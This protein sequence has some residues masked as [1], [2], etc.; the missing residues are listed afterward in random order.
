[1]YSYKE[2]AELAGYTARVSLLFDTMKDVK[3]EKFVKQLVSSSG[4]E[5]N[6]KG[7]SGRF[8]FIMSKED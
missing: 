8:L 5:S 1:M 2:L 4:T 7:N 6:A 3:N